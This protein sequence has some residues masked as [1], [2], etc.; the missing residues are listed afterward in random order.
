[1][2][3]HR[4]AKVPDVLK[5]FGSLK[6]I[7]SN[8]HGSTKAVY[9]SGSK[10]ICTMTREIIN[11]PHLRDL[12]EPAAQ[13][14]GRTNNTACTRAAKTGQSAGPVGGIHMAWS[15][16][17]NPGPSDTVVQSPVA[18]RLQLQPELH[19][20]PPEPC[21]FWKQPRTQAAAWLAETDLSSFVPLP[22]TNEV[23]SIIALTAAVDWLADVGK[24]TI[25]TVTVSSGFHDARGLI[26][27]QFCYRG[28]QQ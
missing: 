22:D 28:G 17:N 15:D 5:E 12:A 6:H 2:K 23:V 9:R 8:F 1:M 10:R 14:S 18:V 4:L 13:T 25:Q 7:T 19:L 20:F 16:F 3:F 26:M 27:C 24:T 11:D 21:E